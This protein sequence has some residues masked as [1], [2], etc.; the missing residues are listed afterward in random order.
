MASDVDFTPWNQSQLWTAAKVTAGFGLPGMYARINAND[1]TMDDSGNPNLTFVDRV[2]QSLPNIINTATGSFSYNLGTNRSANPSQFA[3]GSATIARHFI[4]NGL[5]CKEYEIYNENDGL[6]IGTYSAVFNAAADALHSVDS[7]IKVIGTNDS[8]MNGGRMQSFA[9]QSGS[10]IARFHYHSY[11][12]DPSF[13]DTDIMS[14]CIN[15]FGGDASGLRSAIRGTG[16]ANTPAGIGEYSMDGNPPGDPRQTAIQGAVF[17]LLALYTAFTSDP[18]T[19]HG[20]IWDWMG[21]GYYGMIIDPSN[22][23]AG[24]P[25]FSVVPV[26]YAL[27]IC[28]Q[29]MGGSQVSSRTQG[30]AASLPVIAIKTAAGTGMGV[31]IINYGGS[32]ASG[33]IAFSH[34]PINTTGTATINR[35]EV[36]NANKTANP[37]TLQ[38]TAGLATITIPAMSVTA[39]K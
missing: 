12:V 10:R 38:V 3:A 20:A 33:Q 23:P 32:S 34:W 24:L 27:K 14:Q 11:S 6:D 8:Y 37:T 5:P 1:S 39:H 9:Q 13:N 2:C 19:T 4:S 26:G 29:F 25:A 7:T 28:R 17:N 31:L 30:N 16:N 22:N 15:R 36:S 35:Y 21:D 18:L